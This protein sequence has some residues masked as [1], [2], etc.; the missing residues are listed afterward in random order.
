MAGFCIKSSWEIRSCFGP[1][2]CAS[3][4]GT[5]YI[6]VGIVNQAHGERIFTAATSHRRISAYRNFHSSNLRQ[7]FVLAFKSVFL[8]IEVP[9]LIAAWGDSKIRI[10]HHSR[11][12][13]WS[14]DFAS[15]N[16]R[17]QPFC[18]WRNALTFICSCYWTFITFIQQ[19]LIRRQ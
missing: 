10:F 2:R 15:P 14:G 8:T 12:A 5:L 13:D 19:K 6:A 3:S 17:H 16:W 7:S 18:T 11:T 1:I 9:P 4:F